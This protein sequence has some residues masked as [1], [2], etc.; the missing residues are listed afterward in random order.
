MLQH[1]EFFEDEWKN[2]TSFDM[3]HLLDD[4][5]FSWPYYVSLYFELV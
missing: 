1:V 5:W 4:W 3:A 2:I